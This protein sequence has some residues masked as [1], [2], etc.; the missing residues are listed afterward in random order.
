M[1]TLAYGAFA[2]TPPQMSVN[3]D[4]VMNSQHIGRVFSVPLTQKLRQKALYDP[5]AMSSNPPR[6]LGIHPPG[7]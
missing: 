6:A 2:P 5:M 7:Q 3:G 4:R 1:R